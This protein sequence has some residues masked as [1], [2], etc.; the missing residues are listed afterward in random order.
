M[1]LLTAAEVGT[2]LKFSEST[3]WNW[4]Y[5][6]RAAPTGFPPPV[7]VSN[8]VRWRDYDICK[9]IADLP[10]SKLGCIKPTSQQLEA[11]KLVSAA[12][13]TPSPS[14]PSRGRGRPRKIAA[15]LKGGAA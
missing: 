8:A 2:K 15:V 5:G 12:D 7:N 4:Q 13:S 11:F 14:T 10:F 3:I 6:R 9:F 1:E